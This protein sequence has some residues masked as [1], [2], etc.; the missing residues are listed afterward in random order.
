LEG[1]VLGKT[2]EVSFNGPIQCFCLH[3]I[4]FRQIRIEHHAL[5][6]QQE[7]A[8][9]GLESENVGSHATVKATEQT[10]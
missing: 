10:M 9:L 4:E 2:I 1:E 6:A 7:D 3:S 5:G 8:A